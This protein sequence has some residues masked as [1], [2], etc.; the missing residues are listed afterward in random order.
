MC[1][2][3]LYISIHNM[4]FIIHCIHD[5]IKSLVRTMYEALL[6]LLVFFLAPDF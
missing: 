3:S 6:A 2:S 5:I 1:F 4:V